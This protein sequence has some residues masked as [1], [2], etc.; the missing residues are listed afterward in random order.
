MRCIL[1][2]TSKSSLRRDIPVDHEAWKNIT[3]DSRGACKSPG[4][5]A[6]ET[7]R[8]AR[9][10]GAIPREYRLALERPGRKRDRRS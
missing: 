8:R 9:H 6:C 7:L 10:T 5:R 4:R 3:Q 2:P 1:V